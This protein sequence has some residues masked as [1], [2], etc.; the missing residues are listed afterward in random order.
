MKATPPA[1]L[2]ALYDEGYRLWD[3]GRVENLGD[4]RYRIV[5]ALPTWVHF[6]I[7]VGSLLT[8]HATRETIMYYIE[9]A[10]PACSCESN[11]ANGKQCVHLVAADLQNAIGDSRDLARTLSLPRPFLLLTSES[12]ARNS[13]G[14]QGSIR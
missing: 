7:G 8:D 14:P 13:R 6:E 3:E 9:P 1:D 10:K 4:N 11:R 12:R 2:I 5:Y